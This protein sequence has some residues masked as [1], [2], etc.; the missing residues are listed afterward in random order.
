MA[1]MNRPIIVLT[2][3]GSDVLLLVGFS[4][5]EGLSQLFSYQLDLVAEWKKE[6]A[7]DKL[8]GQKVIIQLAL[9]GGKTR[10][11]SGICVMVLFSIT[12][13]RLEVSASSRGF[14]TLA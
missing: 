2:P 8:L 14:L 13:P 3:L 10:P 11:F 1:T 12:C 6:V 5:K 7:F 4:G 9:A